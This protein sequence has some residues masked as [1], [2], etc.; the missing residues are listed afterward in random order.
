MLDVLDRELGGWPI[1]QGAS[2]KASQ[3]N[4]SR[5]LLTLRAYDNNI[6]YSCGTA[7]DDRNSSMYYI[8]V[9]RRRARDLCGESVHLGFAIGSRP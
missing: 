8:R 7:T 6:V 2:W 9:S 4:L 1:L 3:Y 5:L